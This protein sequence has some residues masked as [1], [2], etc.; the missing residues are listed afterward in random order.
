MPLVSLAPQDV[1]PRFSALQQVADAVLYEGYVLY[2]YRQSSVKNRGPRWQFG[3]LSPLSV[4]RAEDIDDSSVAGSVES[5]FQQT[6]C[7]IEAPRDARLD[8]R[9]RFLH[10]QQKTIEVRRDDGAFAP[11][12]SLDAGERLYVGFDEALPEEFQLSAELTELHDRHV[13]LAFPGARTTEPI[14]DHADD[15]IGR[16]VRQTRQ[17]NARLRLDV[18]RAEA[19]F[20]LSR[21]RIR[22]ENTGA[23]L[24]PHA[25]RD[26]ALR[27]SLVAVHTFVAISPGKFLSSLDPPQWARPAADA[28]R[29][30]HTFPVL[31]GKPG[32]GDLLLS[33]PIILYD[34]PQVAPESPGNLFDATEIDEILSLRTLTLSDDEKRE[35]RATDPRSAEIV[36]RIDAMPPEMMAKLHGAVRSLRPVGVDPISVD[37]EPTLATPAAPT[38]PWW[39]PEA[40]ASVHPETDGVIVDGGEITKGSL[41]RLRPRQRGTDAHDMFLAGRTARV[42]A[43]FLDVDDAT[44]VAVTLDDDPAAELHQWYGRFHYFSPEEVERIDGARQPPS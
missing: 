14:R 1:N 39:A 10:V 8:V 29:N 21:L 15:L 40:D 28:C 23:D 17:L 38:L 34:H 42:E 35:A 5:W 6:E 24:T 16:I 32:S 44:H 4:I 26:D 43:I 7:L 36:D 2:Q 30:I 25:S 33:S 12:R 11:V 9:I 13:E 31:G 18:Q 22:L 37:A 19:P 20:P 27:Y 3:V 41:V